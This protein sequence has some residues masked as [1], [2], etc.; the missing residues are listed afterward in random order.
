MKNRVTIAGEPVVDIYENV[1]NMR[2]W[3]VTK[4]AQKEGHVFLSGY[5]RCLRPHLLAE[6]Q[7]LPE[8][9]LLDMGKHMRKVPEDAWHRCPLVRIED[10]SG[11]KVVRCDGEEA[12]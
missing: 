4:R 6:F 10:C 5:V 12:E 8:E 11:P 3:Y 1:R 7:H 2:C 9:A